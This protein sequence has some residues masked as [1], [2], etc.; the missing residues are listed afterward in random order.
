MPSIDYSFRILTELKNGNR[1]S[2]RDTSLHTYVSETGVGA[3]MSIDLMESQINGMRSCSWVDTK[4][5]SLVSDGPSVYF[6]SDSY[7]TMSQATNKFGDSALKFSQV[8]SGRAA[9]N[10]MKRYKFFGSK[11]C[12]TLGVP[13]NMWL[14]TDTFKLTN[15]SGSSNFMSGEVLADRMQI[16]ESFQISSM[17]SIESNVPINV[18]NEDRILYFITG[19]ETP[20]IMGYDKV[21]DTFGIGL[22]GISSFETAS[23]GA[24]NVLQVGEDRAATFAG[25]VFFQ[26][27]S[28]HNIILGQNN[29]FWFGDPYGNLGVH[30]NYM[31]LANTGDVRI[32]ANDHLLLGFDG[33]QYVAVGTANHD[34]RFTIWT[35]GNHHSDG[36][37]L[38]RDDSSTLSN[39]LFGAIGFDSDDGAATTSSLAAPVYIAG[40]AAENQGP[41]D[42]GGYLTFGTKKINSETG[43]YATERMRIEHD[44]TVVIGITEITGSTLTSTGTIS[45]STVGA[46]N[47]V[48]GATATLEQLTV[49]RNAT[50]NGNIIGDDSTDI[51]NIDEINANQWNTN[52]TSGTKSS[53]QLG[54][55]FAWWYA[56]DPS[57]ARL[58]V[59]GSGLIVNPFGRND[60]H[61]SV[62][63]IGSPMF[64]VDSLNESVTSEVTASFNSTL[65]CDNFSGS[66]TSHLNIIDSNPQINLIEDASDEFVKIRQSGGVL[67]IGVHEDDSVSFGYY[68]SF[69]DNTF[70]EVMTIDMDSSWVGIG[71]TSPDKL[72]H[73]KGTNAQMLIEESTSE[74]MRIGVGET[75][76]TNIIGWHDDAQTLNFGVYSSKS[77]SSIITRMVVSSSG[78]TGIGTTNLI[79][80][81]SML[82]I[83]G[84]SN[85][86]F[87][88]D[89][90]EISIG[91]K[92]YANRRA[93]ISA[94]R[95]V[96]YTDY[97]A[98]G[99]AFKTHESADH[100]VDPVTKMVIDW[101]GKVGIG[102]TNPSASLDVR[103]PGENDKFATLKW[104]NLQEEWIH[105][106]GGGNTSATYE[107]VGQ[108]QTWLKMADVL[109]LNDS[110]YKGCTMQV[111]VTDVHS[112]WGGDPDVKLMTYMVTITKRSS[113]DL[114]RAFISGPS[115]DYVR[116]VKKDNYNY[117]VQV[118]QPA[119]WK[120][121]NLHAK[122]LEHN[123]GV[124][125]LW[126]TGSGT[127]GLVVGDDGSGGTIYDGSDDE[128]TGNYVPHSHFF[129]YIH[130]GTNHDYTDIDTNAQSIAF[131]TFTGT[132]G[133]KTTTTSV[134]HGVTNGK[135][136]IVAVTV[137]VAT[138]EDNSGDAAAGDMIA[139]GSGYLNDADEEVFVA[140]DDTEIHLY[141][142]GNAD[143]VTGQR[144][145]GLIT[146]TKE[147]LY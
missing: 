65:K 26:G 107:S 31:Q 10:P 6:T 122:I 49:T 41:G 58:K 73:I 54:N 32:S 116:V 128:Y 84:P 59:S 136:R 85:P 57:W 121:I 34:Y 64:L 18:E 86:T 90:A 147:D 52:D 109:F 95:S 51:T 114:N 13:E 16:K 39:N 118:Q 12:Q 2:Y 105:N 24:D 119:L 69:A 141:I 101:D 142:D 97:D 44:G 93:A 15:V 66:F 126:P 123:T 45:G 89:W 132:L 100:L 82:H 135:K 94:F 68:G 79:G 144:F 102:T 131:K 55:D 130:T 117:E 56:Q 30:S 76:K 48:A 62:G 46:N 127:T 36:M 53:I 61:F 63:T 5:E 11:I 129:P 22:G 9:I 81:K 92:D 125:V 103:A 71:E 106:F 1:F 146:Y 108:A 4:D 133:S 124:K 96:A 27:S 8:Q 37:L 140:Y 110:D 91:S 21:N 60:C 87:G 134:T 25:D 19:S 112:N 104:G 83:G 3:T 40:Y 23:S 75:E 17:G 42:K 120:D 14:Q 80:N 35:D 143:A 139:V 7:M 88:E 78:H 145:T 98:I 28:N 115:N 113:T 43:D 99:L 20:L 77:D 72:F 38:I 74:F 33:N 29:K 111:D 67:E 138:T 70:D 137:N 50:F 47:L